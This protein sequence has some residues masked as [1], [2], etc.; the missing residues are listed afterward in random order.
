MKKNNVVLLFLIFGLLGTGTSCS[1]SIKG[2]FLTLKVD[3][4][5]FEFKD[6]AC[7]Y[8]NAAFAMTIGT[9]AANTLGFYINSID[10]EGSFY[11]NA[12]ESNVA[13]YFPLKDGTEIYIR[14][15]TVIVTEF[16]DKGLEGTLS[17]TGINSLTGDEVAISDGR[18]SGEY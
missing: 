16:T 8:A 2:C 13:L 9:G 18:F 4:E 3:G 11:T 6:A 10:A 15:I 7:V 17:G 12:N 5:L 1:K 14:E